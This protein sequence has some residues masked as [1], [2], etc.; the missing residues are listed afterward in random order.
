[1]VETS[2]PPDSSDA[3]TGDQTSDA[4]QDG[5]S[6]GTYPETEE[7]RV[8]RIRK[9]KYPLDP[10]LQKKLRE[11]FPL[12]LRRGQKKKTK[13]HE[14]E[15]GTMLRALGINPTEAQ[16]EA[17]KDLARSKEAA[18]RVDNTLTTRMSNKEWRSSC[19]VSRVR[20]YARPKKISWKLS[21]YSLGTGMR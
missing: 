9:E 12:L 19:S 16:I 6:E 2:P 4:S 13:L 11:T 7:E 5:E 1:M 21:K 20:W 18:T 10:E 17:V 15:V 8:E 14:T 3:A